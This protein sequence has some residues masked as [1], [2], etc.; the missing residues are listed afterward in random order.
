MGLYSKSIFVP[1]GTQ[2]TN[3]IVTTVVLRE[4]TITQISVLM[5]TVATKGVVLV[6]ISVGLAGFKVWNLPVDN[7]DWI[8]KAEQYFENI[9]LPQ[10]GL[11]LQII[12]ASPTAQKNHT[13]MCSIHT[14]TTAKI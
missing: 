14:A 5:D 4:N 13:V 1:A 2:I 9:V 3:P 11:P 8:I 12:C 10:V 6:K 7:E